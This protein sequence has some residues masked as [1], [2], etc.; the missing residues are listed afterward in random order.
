MSDSGKQGEFDG[1]G[2]YSQVV[3]V[4]IIGP[5]EFRLA[6]NYPNPFNPE[7][8]I[9]YAL[10]VDSKVIL[11]VFNILGQEVATLLNGEMTAGTHNVT[12]DASKLNSGVYI[13]KI[14]ARGEDGSNF[15]AA[16]K[17]I[18]TK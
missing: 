3:E 12:F 7:T 8:R 18:L 14:E 16:K 2:E 17:M 15:T 11:R 1:S 9:D 4:K 10:K 6:Q 5:S 13:Y